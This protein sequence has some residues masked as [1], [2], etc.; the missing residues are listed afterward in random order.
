MNISFIYDKKE[1]N[2][3]LPAQT[4]LNYIK[5]LISKIFKFESLDIYYKG[6][7]IIFTDDDKTTL[8][9]DIVTEVDST[10]KL[11]IINPTLNNTKNQNFSNSNSQSGIVKNI[12]K[13]EIDVNEIFNKVI[14]VRKGIHNNKLFETLYTQKIKKLNSAL[15]EFNLKII[16]INNFLFRK[17]VGVKK[18]ILTTFEKKIYDFIDNLIIYIKNL[19]NILEINNFV[20]Y[21]VIVQNLNIFYPEL[22]DFTKSNIVA[23]DIHLSAI[24][25]KERKNNS[26]ISNFPLNLKRSDINYSINSDRSN[27]FNKST[28]KPSIKRIFLL[29]SNFNYNIDLKGVNIKENKKSNDNKEDKNK[30]KEKNKIKKNDNEEEDKS[31][32]NKTENIF[33][34]SSEGTKDKINDNEKDNNNKNDNNE[35]FSDICKK[36][37]DDISRITSKTVKSNES[38]KNMLNEEEIKNLDINITSLSSN[39]PNN[40]NLNKEKNKSKELKM[41]N[42][43]KDNKNNENKSFKE[44]I[45]SFKNKINSYNPRFMPKL[46]S[47]NIK[48][49]DKNLNSTIH[50]NENENLTNSSYDCV[51]EKSKNE[52]KEEEKIGEEEEEEESEPNIK[53]EEKTN[54]TINKNEDSILKEDKKEKSNSEEKEENDKK[55]SNDSLEKI[56]KLVHGLIPSKAEEN[57]NYFNMEENNDNIGINTPIYQISSLNNS[58]MLKA[59]SRKNIMKKK[60]SKT[61]NK[62]D[63]II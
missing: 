47:L 15:K 31:K 35:N 14:I 18:D 36:S 16:E 2:F 50:E 56:S 61:A 48:K 38:N 30:E 34:F 51:K 26:L 42:D 24:R 25:E 63:F 4:T 12:D 11:K 6:N 10:V 33:D 13:E 58:D 46:K 1:Y 23:K 22:Y 28:K 21:D 54:S 3:D 57:N 44:E 62:Y 8:L 20:T 45:K 32:E 43:M 39:N 9:K 37:I 53:K 52:E 55:P 29:D 49:S 60:K 40:L 59:L 17:N 19:T 41:K 27:Y 7:K 5:K